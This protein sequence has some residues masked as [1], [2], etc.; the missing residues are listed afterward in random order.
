MS[1]DADLLK[2]AR[3]L[4]RLDRKKPKQSSLR[5]AV[6]T[7][8]YS[9]FHLLVREASR[10][11]A[12][13][14]PPGLRDQV[15][16]AFDHSSMRQVCAAF[17]GSST[18]PKGIQGLLATPI[19]PE[20]RAVA[21]LFVD[22]QTQRHDADYNMTAKFTRLQVLALLRNSRRTV[23]NWKRMGNS[24]NRKLFIAALLLN[25]LWRT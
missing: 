7:A 18:M 13:P 11:A 20:L 24:P 21:K 2:L 5:R 12:P 19:E 10:Q 22:L 6:S 4:V 25:R 23:R 14:A 15:A 17:S 16:R 8:Y 1:L 9:V 3:R